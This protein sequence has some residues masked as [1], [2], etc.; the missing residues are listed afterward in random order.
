MR[1]S[2]FD[3][4]TS[5]MY[6]LA[7]SNRGLAEAFKVAELPI[8]DLIRLHDVGERRREREREREEDIVCD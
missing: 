7:L 8:E 5:M 6:A 2:I 3:F 4:N 1:E